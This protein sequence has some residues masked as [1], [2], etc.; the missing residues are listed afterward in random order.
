MSLQ[1]LYF[2]AAVVFGLMA[3]GE[4]PYYAELHRLPEYGWTYADSLDFS[5]AVKDTTKRYDLMLD[6]EHSPDFPYSNFYVQIHTRYP[7]GKELKQAVSL[8]LAAKSGLW[9]GRCNSKRCSLS[10]PLQAGIRFAEPGTYHLL[11]EQ[12]SRR[13]TLPGIFSLALSLWEK[14]SN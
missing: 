14:P 7:G 11:I 12:Y 2:A 10:I 1:S 4:S 8:E 5:F 6:L 3:C 13:D 9:F